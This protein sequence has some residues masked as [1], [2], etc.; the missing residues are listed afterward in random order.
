[1]PWLDKA[2]ALSSALVLFEWDNETEAP[3][4][5]AGL[6]SKAIEILSDEYYKIDY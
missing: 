4:E 6:T 3:E 5:S 2:Y 1:M